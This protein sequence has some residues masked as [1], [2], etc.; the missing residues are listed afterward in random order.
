MRKIKSVTFIVSFL[1]GLLADDIEAAV[2]GEAGHRRVLLDAGD[3]V[4]EVEPLGGEHSRVVVVNAVGGKTEGGGE[5]LGLGAV[6]DGHAFAAGEFAP[7]V[8]LV[9][10]PQPGADEGETERGF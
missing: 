1:S 9:V 10:R 8:E 2:G 5:F 6:V 4:H 7:A 3:D